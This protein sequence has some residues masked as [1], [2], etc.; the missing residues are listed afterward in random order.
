ML[1]DDV[2][3]LIALSADCSQ[4]N[5]NEMGL[6]DGYY[7]HI[8]PVLL[9]IAGI[10]AIGYGVG[11]QLSSSEE[12]SEIR[13]ILVRYEIAESESRRSEPHSVILVLRDG[14]RFWTNAVNKYE[15]GQLFGM[16]PARVRVFIERKAPPKLKTGAVKSYGLTVNG[17]DIL[18]LDAALR[19]EMIIARYGLPVLGVLAITGGVLLYVIKKQRKGGG[20]IKF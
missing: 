2:G 1:K 13:G 18:T 8:K 19:R 16:L 10:A 4:R 17:Q 12:F 5:H 6:L 14:R 11:T 15:A 9:V 7:A 3:V 20:K